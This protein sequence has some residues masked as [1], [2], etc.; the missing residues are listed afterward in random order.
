MQAHTL[1]QHH[2][3]AAAACTLLQGV[4]LCRLAR[5]VHMCKVR[6]SQHHRKSLQHVILNIASST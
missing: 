2:P 1:P 4:L 3:V 5:R 6:A